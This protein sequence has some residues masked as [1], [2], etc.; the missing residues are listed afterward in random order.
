MNQVGHFALSLAWILTIYGMVAGGIGA[1]KNQTKW[2]ISAANGTVAGA[3]CALVAIVSLGSSF[4]SDDYSIQYVWQFSNAAMPGIYKI[5]A[6]W[7]GMDGS[8]LSAFV[9]VISGHCAISASGSAGRRR[10]R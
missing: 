6:I 8:M 9:S 1:L 5:A 10:S 7:G 3:A 2:V 4:L